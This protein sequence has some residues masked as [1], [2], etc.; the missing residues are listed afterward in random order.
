[1]KTAT[2]PSLRVEP[3]LRGAIEELLEEGE[4]LSGFV[5]QAVRENIDRRRMQ[6]EFVRRGLLS[7]DRARHEQNYIEADQVIGK[8]ETLLAEAKTGKLSRA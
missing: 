1:M 5:E 3:E 7:R 8:L 4:S 6:A 2:L